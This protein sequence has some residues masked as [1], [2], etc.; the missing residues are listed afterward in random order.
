[1]NKNQCTFV[2]RIASVIKH[3]KT[4]NGDDYIWFMLDINAKENA[5]SAKANYYQKINILC[6]K[7]N[8]IKYLERIDAKSGN[9]VVVFGFVN[10]FTSNIK[11]QDVVSN[12][13]NANEVYV[14]KLK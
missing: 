1:M 9:L 11:G 4:Q 7:K 6:F 14:V 3:A 5:N 13:I 2:G 8:I 12:G 10:T